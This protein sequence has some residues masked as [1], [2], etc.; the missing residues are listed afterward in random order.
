[1]STQLL[2]FNET[3]VREPIAGRGQQAAAWALDEETRAIGRRH[4]AEARAILRARRTAA[5][6]ASLPRSGERPAA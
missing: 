4:V 2:L 6:R 1:M 5:G 3:A